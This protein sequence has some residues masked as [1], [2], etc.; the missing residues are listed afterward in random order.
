MIWPEN[1]FFLRELRRRHGFGLL[2]GVPTVLMA[3]LLTLLPVLA[4]LVGSLPFFHAALPWGTSAW[5]WVFRPHLYVLLYIGSAW[6]SRVLLVE[7]LGKTLEDLQLLPLSPGRILSGKLQLPLLL[8]VLLA[9]GLFPGALLTAMLGIISVD[10]AWSTCGL[11]FSLSVF[12]VL[13]FVSLDGVRM[14]RDSDFRLGGKWWAYAR[15]L[16]EVGLVLPRLFLG[17]L[18]PLLAKVGRRILDRHGDVRFFH[19]TVPLEWMV[20]AAIA[21]AGLAAYGAMQAALSETSEALRRSARVRWLAFLLEGICG[22]RS[23]GRFHPSA[24]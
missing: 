5:N 20:G 18:A 1:P 2:R 14:P 8:A 4:A 9:T 11:C 22:W 21:C 16:G 24:T 6:G 15:S 23:S 10:R 13:C 19:E 17:L 3:A 12:A 7:R